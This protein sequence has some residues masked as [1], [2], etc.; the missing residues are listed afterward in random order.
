MRIRQLLS[1]AIPVVLAIAVSVYLNRTL[2]QTFGFHPGG[3]AL[4]SFGMLELIAIT[5]LQAALFLRQLLIPR[6]SAPLRPQRGHVLLPWAIAVVAI[7]DTALVIASLAYG[8][9]LMGQ[10]FAQRAFINVEAVRAWD[11]AYFFVHQIANAA[12]LSAPDIFGAP[13]S[14]LKHNPEFRLFAFC[15]LLL[16]VWATT[17]FVVLLMLLFSPARA[18]IARTFLGLGA[19]RAGI[20]PPTGTANP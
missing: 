4:F 12:L 3:T 8:C 5:I 7:I 14:D 13:L 15:L 1:F 6:Q 17:K 16:N 2:A 11:A 19:N 18:L 20:V 10:P 9:E